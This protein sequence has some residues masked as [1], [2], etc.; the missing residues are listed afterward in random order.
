MFITI[1]G[2]RSQETESGILPEYTFNAVLE[3]SNNWLKIKRCRRLF[4][5]TFECYIRA[6]DF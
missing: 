5:L 6:C 1:Q 3:M 2:V 4:L